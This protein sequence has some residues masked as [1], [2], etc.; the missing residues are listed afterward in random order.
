MH[1]SHEVLATL[2]NEALK[3]KITRTYMRL[4]LAGLCTS[5]LK[6]LK[7]EEIIS[8]SMFSSPIT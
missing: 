7:R 6:Y 8:P 1:F 2:E 5:F 3:S 4:L